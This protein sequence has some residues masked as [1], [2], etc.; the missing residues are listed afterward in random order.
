MISLAKAGALDAK[1]EA[2]EVEAAEAVRPDVRGVCHALIRRP[3]VAPLHRAEGP[4]ASPLPVMLPTQAFGVG[5]TRTT[6]HRAT[7]LWPL[8]VERA[9]VEG[10]AVVELAEASCLDGRA[11]PLKGAVERLPGG[12]PDGG[13]QRPPLPHAAIVRRA[14]AARV[15]GAATTGDG[16]GLHLFRA[17]PPS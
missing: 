5:L 6:C 13:I 16:A 11:A 3:A 9:T 10:A 14:K 17:P 15:E 8:A 1:T 2:V 12:P 4:P 7:L